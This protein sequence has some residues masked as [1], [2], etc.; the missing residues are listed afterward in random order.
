MA[1]RMTWVSPSYLVAV[2][3]Q[4]TLGFLTSKKI[5]TDITFGTDISME[6]SWLQLLIVIIGVG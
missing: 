4:D 3:V 6:G 1:S 2:C 5:S